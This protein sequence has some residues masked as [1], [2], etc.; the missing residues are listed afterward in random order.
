MTNDCA[1]QQTV[2]HRNISAFRYKRFR[3][4]QIYKT[5]RI[6]GGAY[7]FFVHAWPE[8]TLA[9]NTGTRLPLDPTSQHLIS[10]PVAKPADLPKQLGKS[11]RTNLVPGCE[12]SCLENLRLRK[13]KQLV[14]PAADNLMRPIPAPAVTLSQQPHTASLAKIYI[15]GRRMIH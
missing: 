1:N 12:E 8:A 13:G 7:G 14:V 6:P 9:E 11:G 10:K 4:R 15:I 3:I 5:E 2:L